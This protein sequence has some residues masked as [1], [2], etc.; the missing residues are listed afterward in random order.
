M[1]RSRYSIT[2]NLRKFFLEQNLPLLQNIPQLR[3]VHVAPLRHSNLKEH[4]RLGSTAPRAHTRHKTH[5]THHH[6]TSR[7]VAH[8]T[9]QLQLSARAVLWHVRLR[10]GVQRASG[11]CDAAVERGFRFHF[12]GAGKLRCTWGGCSSSIAMMVE[13]GSMTRTSLARPATG[14]SRDQMQG[15]SGWHL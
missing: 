11:H 3:I 14:V 13:A 1:A 5:H 7:H 12:A 9:A 2:I 4:S 8:L 6:V 10:K 15:E